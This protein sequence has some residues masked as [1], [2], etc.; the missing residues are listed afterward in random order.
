V[1]P[2]YNGSTFL[3]EAVES[4]FAQTCLPREILVVDDASTDGTPELVASLAQHA[5]VPLRLLRLS[6]NSGGPARPMN[7]GIAEATG[8]FIAVLD[9][10]DVFVPTKLE[11]Q[12]EILI[13]QPELA[14]VF[15]LS[16]SYANPQQVMQPP[17]VVRDLEQ[18]PREHGR[19]HRLSGPRAL[20]LYLQYGNCATGYPGFLFRRQ[21]WKRKGGVD[22]SLRIG[23]DYDLACWL[24]TQGSVAFLP[25]VGYLCRRHGQNLTKRSFLASHREWVAVKL[26]YLPQL[27]QALADADLR[28]LLR[29]QA[30]GLAYHLRN[31]GQY[32]EALR[33]LYSA[34]R[35]CGW[36]KR[37]ASA[38]AKLV[39][40]WLYVQSLKCCACYRPGTP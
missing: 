10:D 37:M 27:P 39:P 30:L 17:E 34:Q 32:W 38:F 24:T 9:Q 25:E 36:D 19:Y 11:V 28:Q 7:I 22:E 23:S 21:D 5:P 14:F 29:R 40:H 16:A 4:V 33:Y 8:E 3:R 12:S 31:A 18:F 13:R 15:S 1:I 26:R 35:R 6:Q 2:S 20:Q